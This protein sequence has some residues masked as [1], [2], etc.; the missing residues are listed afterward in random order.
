MKLSVADGNPNPI[1]ASVVGGIGGKALFVGRPQDS[2]GLGY[3]YYAF[4]NELRNALEPT[5]DLDDEQGVEMFY[6]YEVTPWFYIT[7]DIQYIDPA[8]GSDDNVLI[9]GL[10]TNIRF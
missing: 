5:T 1:D 6:S 9:A 7:A 2:F 10:R 3:F 8:S 4:S